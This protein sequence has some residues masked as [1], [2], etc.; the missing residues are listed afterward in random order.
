MN[1]DIQKRIEEDTQKRIDEMTKWSKEF[2]KEVKDGKLVLYH[3]TSEKY[4][5]KIIE[6]GLKPR[7]KRKSNWEEGIGKSRPDLVYLTNCYAAF[8]ASH[9]STKKDK[10]VVLKIEIDTR[11]FIMYPDEEFVFRTLFGSGKGLSHAEAVEA[12]NEIDPTEYSFWREGLQFMG[13][14]STNFIPV[15]N[16]VGY[17]IG[18]GMEFLMNCDPSIS[19]LNYRFMG[20]SY[21]AYLESLEYQPLVAQKIVR[22]TP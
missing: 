12:Y 9:V 22:G 4:L 16:I 20:G 14:V 3:G 2:G 19:P 21:K 17:A 7:G 15:E 5:K 11:D 13:T 10:P 6:E 18:D 1:K 8:Y